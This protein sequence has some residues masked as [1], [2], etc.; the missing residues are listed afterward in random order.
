MDGGGW[1]A[2]RY[3]GRGVERRHHGS[4]RT[5]KEKTFADAHAHRCALGVPP[6]NLPPRPENCGIMGSVRYVAD[7]SPNPPEVTSCVEDEKARFFC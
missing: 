1:H 5:P 4:I 6:T 7:N 2:L 3:E